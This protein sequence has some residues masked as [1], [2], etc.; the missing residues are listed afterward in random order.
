MRALAQFTKTTLIG[1][2]LVILPIYV[3]VLL[4]AKAV[5]GLLDLLGPVAGALPA[6]VEWRQAAAIVLLI[7]L[8]FVLGLAVRTGPGLRAKNAVELAVLERVPGYTFFRGLAKRLTGSSDEAQLE[9]ALVEI[10]EALVPALI[11]ER[12]EDGSYTVLV[13]SAPTPMAGSIY[14]LPADR[15]HPC[16]LPFTTAIAVFS[17]WGMGAGAFVRAMK[18]PEKLPERLRPQLAASLEVVDVGMKQP[19]PAIIR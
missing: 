12:L 9:P 11:V 15:V 4:L 13:P 8:C 6:G 7:F 5:K 1:G 2:V 3:C 18:A 19:E 10:E 14:I 16:D 17:K